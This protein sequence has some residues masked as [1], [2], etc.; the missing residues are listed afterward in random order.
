MFVSTNELDLHYYQIIFKFNGVA[1]W[2]GLK[3]I[4]IK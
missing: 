2:E 1:Y 3:W 4:K